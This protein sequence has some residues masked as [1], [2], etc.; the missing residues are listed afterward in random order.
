MSSIWNSANL[1]KYILYLFNYM[2][3]PEF[4]KSF[5]VY[6]YLIKLIQYFNAFILSI[7]YLG[8]ILLE[9]FFLNCTFITPTPWLT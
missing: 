2:T 4:I 1:F 5:N 6:Y 7:S 3:R 8:V 9:M